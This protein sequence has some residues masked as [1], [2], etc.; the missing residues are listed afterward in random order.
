MCLNCWE[1]LPPAYMYGLCL[2]WGCHGHLMTMKYHLGEGLMSLC[3]WSLSFLEP[4]PL[5]GLLSCHVHRKVLLSL[6]QPVAGCQGQCVLTATVF[7][8]SAS[9]VFVFISAPLKQFFWG[10]FVSTPL[11]GWTVMAWESTHPTFSSCV[12]VMEV[13]FPGQLLFGCPPPTPGHPFESG[14][15]VLCCLKNLEKSLGKLI[16]WS[17]EN[18]GSLIPIVKLPFSS[19]FCC[20]VSTLR[21]TI[22]QTWSSPKKLDFY[23]DGWKESQCVNTS[24]PTLVW[25]LV[26][27]FEPGE[28]RWFYNL[29]LVPPIPTFSPSGLPWHVWFLEGDQAAFPKMSWAR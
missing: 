23:H 2:W 12:W 22:K 3:C 1:R 18:S 26:C 21:K 29:L 9:R 14:C 8:S 15:C 20:W 17:D 5:R 28:T 6:S 7:P 10:S 4:E 19:S 13:W 27:G 25:Q 11:Q 16:T 24:P